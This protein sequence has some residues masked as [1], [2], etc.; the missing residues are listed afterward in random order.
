[1]VQLIELHV[2]LRGDGT[3]SYKHFDRFMC[4]RERLFNF[5]IQ[6]FLLK[7][8]IEDMSSKFDYYKDTE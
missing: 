8:L 2:S 7:I 5:E 3:F 1:M 4:F 6:N